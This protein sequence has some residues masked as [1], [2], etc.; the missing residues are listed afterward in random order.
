MSIDRRRL[1]G[2]TGFAAAERAMGL[3]ALVSAPGGQVALAAAD[4][5]QLKRRRRLER[6]EILTER[7]RKKAKF[8][9]EHALSAVSGNGD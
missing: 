2:L 7:M 5:D 4:E 1:L 9:L 8:A 3:V 6:L